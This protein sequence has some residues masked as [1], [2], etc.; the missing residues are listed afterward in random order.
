METIYTERYR[1]CFELNLKYGGRNLLRI[2]REVRELGYADFN[3]RIL[4]GRKEDGVY[5]PVAIA[6]GTYPLPKVVSRE[7]IWFNIRLPLYGNLRL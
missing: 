2:E 7:I 1:A 3:R 4:Y 5:N 6:P